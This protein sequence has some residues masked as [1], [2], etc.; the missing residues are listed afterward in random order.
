V[1]QILFPSS[2]ID[3]SDGDHGGVE[4]T[5]RLK[6]TAQNESDMIYAVVICR[7]EDG[8]VLAALMDI[9]SAKAGETVSFSATS[10]SLPASVSASSIASYNAYA[11]PMQIQF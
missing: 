10:L 9:V 2:D 8:K 4:A 11:Y 3:I 7:G 5:G 1:D 6:N